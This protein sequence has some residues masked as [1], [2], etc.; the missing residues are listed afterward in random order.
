[1]SPVADRQG[2]MQRYW[3]WEEARMLNIQ[4]PAIEQ[5][6]LVRQTGS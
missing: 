6:V 1:M 5:G 4:T 2:L 3:V